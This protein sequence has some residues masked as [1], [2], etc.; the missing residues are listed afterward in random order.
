[1]IERLASHQPLP[2]PSQ[3]SC[4]SHGYRSAWAIRW[5]LI[6]D[7]QLARRVAQVDC[8][9][10]RDSDSEK[11][12]LDTL[13]CARVATYLCEWRVRHPR[14]LNRLHEGRDEDYQLLAAIGLLELLNVSNCHD[15]LVRDVELVRL[16]VEGRWCL[17][18]TRSA[19]L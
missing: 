12:G 6:V 5:H 4:D 8:L 19:L 14:R 18:R 17:L 3:A 1:M 16:H 13:G 2:S 7:H 10:A 9:M 15:R 11:E